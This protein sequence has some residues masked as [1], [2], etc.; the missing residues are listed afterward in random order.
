V[1]F[2]LALCVLFAS[3][4]TTSVERPI[5]FFDIP[6]ASFTI[7]ARGEGSWSIER[8]VLEYGRATNQR[9][10]FDQETS[11]VLNQTK[12]PLEKELVVLPAAVHSVVETLLVEVGYTLTVKR[13][14]EPRLVKVEHGQRGGL[15][16]VPQVNHADLEPWRDRPAYV[17]GT[18]IMLDSF[19]TIALA[20]SLRATLS[21][22]GLQTIA[23]LGTSGA[24][25]VQGPGPWVCEVTEMLLDVDEAARAKA[26][27]SDPEE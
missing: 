1:R 17:V 20:N 21:G 23:P 26:S 7:P 16:R 18:F 19:D 25:H 15:L 22:E 10:L 4:A 11:A 12:V 9:F 27:H 13:A 6:G 3:C 2:V 14:A 5:S 24:L 8:L